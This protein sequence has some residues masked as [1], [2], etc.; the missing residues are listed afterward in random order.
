MSCCALPHVNHVY[1]YINKCLV[2]SKFIYKNWSEVHLM[3]FQ[4]SM[5]RKVIV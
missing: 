5:A 4:K 1:M 2:H 3:N